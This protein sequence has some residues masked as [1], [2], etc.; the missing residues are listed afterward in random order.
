MMDQQRSW[1]WRVRSICCLARCDVVGRGYGKREE[2]LVDQG[3]QIGDHVETHRSEKSGQMLQIFHMHK[4]A[5][6]FL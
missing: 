4:P 6:P 3:T 2:K 5:L 1:E